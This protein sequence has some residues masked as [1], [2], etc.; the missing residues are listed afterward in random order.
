MIK[1]R[2]IWNFEVDAARP[3]A[4]AAFPPAIKE[5]WRWEARCFWPEEEVVALAGLPEGLLDLPMAEL[6][7]RQD[8]YLLLPDWHLN[9]KYRRGELL[10]KPRMQTGKAAQA[11]AKKINLADLIE[12]APLPGEPKLTGSQLK[13]LLD[14]ARLVEV[15]KTA[16]MV[17]WPSTPKCKLEF[18][19]LRLQDQVFWSLSIESRAESLTEGLMQALLP[20]AK[21]ADY[22]SFLKQ[23]LRLR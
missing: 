15:H 11:F 23:Q 17:P 18:A 22:V 9:L 19:R 14:E 16:L 3:I 10:Y 2:L 7:E 6:S 8:R 21:P 4:C 13:A 5:D 12:D 20:K 1:K